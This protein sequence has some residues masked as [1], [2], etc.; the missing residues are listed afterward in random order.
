MNVQVIIPLYRPNEKFLELLQMLLRQRDCDYK[1]LLIDSGSDKEYL[2]LVKDKHN[3]QIIDIE[4]ADFN[5]GSTRQ[6]GINKN[7]FS[8][9]YVFMTQD[10]I[11][12]DEYAVARLVEVFDKDD[13]GCAY[14][15][16]L[17]H[18]ESSIFAKIAREYNYGENSY[19]YYFLDR[20]KY[21][22]KTAFISNSFAAYRGTALKSV[23]GFP[24]NTILCEDMYV[25]AKMLMND[26]GVAYVPQARV[27]HSHNYSLLEESKRYFDIGVFHAREKW[28]RNAF[29]TAEKTGRG[30][31]KYE[32]SR[33]IKKPWLL[34]EMCIRDGGKYI[35]YRLGLIENRLP[36]IVK[37]NISM[38][39][40]Y[41]K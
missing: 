12:V 20:K 15:R 41:W 14:G 2:K 26:Y 10:A 8:D 1:V 29:G 6:M 38:N 13:I 19:V 40:R 32:F 28:I 3:V 37:K 4:P 30:F 5:H 18:K 25:A 33:M 34:P 31:L 27:Y 23:G 35:C 9:I 21:G 24:S 11:L 16:Q 7:P 39:S 36:N 22:V 17:P